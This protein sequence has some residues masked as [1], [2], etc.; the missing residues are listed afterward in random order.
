M[1]ALGLNCAEQLSRVEILNSITV[2]VTK[3]PNLSG[4]RLVADHQAYD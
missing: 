4:K 2:G 1:V 3:I